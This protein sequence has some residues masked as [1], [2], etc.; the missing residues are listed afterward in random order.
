MSYE[1]NNIMIGNMFCL[2]KT[3]LIS[4]YLWK[5]DMTINT[6]SLSSCF[7]RKLESYYLET[8]NSLSYNHVVIFPPSHSTKT[9]IYIRP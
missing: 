6:A 2:E 9:C 7:E 3:Q 4:E 5:P 8:A 1:L